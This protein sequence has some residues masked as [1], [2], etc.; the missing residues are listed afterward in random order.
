MITQEKTKYDN[1]K[2]I[3]YNVTDSKENKFLVESA[4]PKH[5]FERPKK[6]Q[7]EAIKQGKLYLV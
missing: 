1:K 4:I 2:V 5:F 6:W 3:K 7:T